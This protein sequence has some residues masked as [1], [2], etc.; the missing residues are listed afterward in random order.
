LGLFIAYWAFGFLTEPLWFSVWISACL[1]VGGI[2]LATR[3]VPEAV[4][5]I[6]RDDL[7]PGELSVI[8]LALIATGAVYSG[9]FNMAFSWFE[10]PV[11]WIGPFSSF[12]RAMI[13]AGFFTLFLSP[14]ATNQGI[15]WPRWYLLLFAGVVIAAVAFMIGYTINVSDPKSA[16]FDFTGVLKMIR[17][18]VIRQ[19]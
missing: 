13:V 16:M 1:L 3:T 17:L 10:R 8:G 11:S 7:G 19:A 9:I 5:I 6:K 18:F 14:D 12:G 2:V 4:S 15:K